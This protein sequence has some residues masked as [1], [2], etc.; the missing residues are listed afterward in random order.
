MIFSGWNTRT[1]WIDVTRNT[2]DDVPAEENAEN[3]RAVHM[4]PVHP[5]G[6]NTSDFVERALENHSGGDKRYPT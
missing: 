1:D 3:D 2:T 5:R 6:T 4:N